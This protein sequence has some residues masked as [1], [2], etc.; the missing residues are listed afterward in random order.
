M[1]LDLKVAASRFTEVGSY[2]LSF[3]SLQSDHKSLLSKVRTELSDVTVAPNFGDGTFS[4][5]LTS[6]V[7]NATVSV[8]AFRI[9][10]EDSH[11]FEMH[12]EE[13]PIFAI[14]KAKNIG[15]AKIV[16][17][18]HAPYLHA[19]KTV[20]VEAPFVKQRRVRFEELAT[21]FETMLKHPRF[22]AAFEDFLLANNTSRYLHFYQDCK[23][24]I[25]A[26][27]A[28]PGHLQSSVYF[29]DVMG[30]YE[31]Y[32]HVTAA[33]HLLTD[34]WVEK[35]IFEQLYTKLE[36]MKAIPNDLK[37]VEILTPCVNEAWKILVEDLH[38]KFLDSRE[39]LT[40]QEK[41]E[42]NTKGLYEINE[43]TGL[44]GIELVQVRTGEKR[45]L[46]IDD[47]M[48]SAETHLSTF[49]VLIRSGK[50]IFKWGLPETQTKPTIVP[51]KVEVRMIDKVMA[52]ALERYR[53]TIL[54]K[55][56]L[57]RKIT[58]L[59]SLR[60]ELDVSI[61][62]CMAKT[63]KS[64]KSDAPVW[65]EELIFQV[66]DL[67]LHGA[68]EFIRFDIVEES[69]ERWPSLGG[70]NIPVEFCRD[71]LQHDLRISFD[72]T[73]RDYGHEIQP[74]TLSFSVEF[75]ASP[76]E[77]ENEM[78]HDVN[79]AVRSQVYLE[80][81]DAPMPMD[82][83]HVL[84]TVQ[85]L[86]VQSFSKYQRFM[87]ATIE[88]RTAKLPTLPFVSVPIKN[89]I[90]PWE[91]PDLHV[92]K[93]EE[94]RNGD[95]KGLEK[96]TLVVSIP[97]INGI[98]KFNAAFKWDTQDLPYGFGINYFARRRNR[99]NF[100]YVGF[101]LLQVPRN[102]EL[103]GTI[104]KFA[105]LESEMKIGFQ[106]GSFPA[107]SGAFR[108][109]S[110]SNFLKEREQDGDPFSPLDAHPMAVLADVPSVNWTA[111][112]EENNLLPTV[113]G[114]DG[115]NEKNVETQAPPIKKPAPPPGKKVRDSPHRSI[116]QI[117]TGVSVKHSNDRPSASQLGAQLMQG[118]PSNL[119]L[120]KNYD[121][122]KSE[123]F[124]E[125]PEHEEPNVLWIK[126]IR[127]PA[128]RDKVEGLHGRLS[129]E[130]D[131]IESMLNTA[132]QHKRVNAEKKSNSEVAMAL[133]KH[134]SMYPDMNKLPT[135]KQEMY[136]QLVEARAE[137]KKT[138]ADNMKLAAL[139]QELQH[140]I[141]VIRHDK[142]HLQK[143]LD[144]TN[145][146]RDSVAVELRLARKRLENHK[147]TV[148]SAAESAIGMR[149]KLKLHVQH[150]TSALRALEHE[151]EKRKRVEQ[152]AR[153]LKSAQDAMEQASARHAAAAAAHMSRASENIKQSNHLE[154][155]RFKI[156]MKAGID[157]AL[158][159][160]KH[161]FVISEH[162]AHAL[163]ELTIHKKEHEHDELAHQLADAKKYIAKLEDELQSMRMKNVTAELAMMEV[164][165]GMPGTLSVND[166]DY[167][168]TMDNAPAYIG[169]DDDDDTVGRGSVFRTKG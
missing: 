143:E 44:L 6:S 99:P 7:P 130:V 12:K 119:P 102:I 70:F 165:L 113:D 42:G 57:S 16:L 141:E 146:K 18:E 135:T 137:T 69:D 123:W 48:G 34:V 36:H 132:L 107:M 88:K 100:L 10:V 58:I 63:S 35:D 14:D 82:C 147:S 47:R 33:Q 13:E 153:E 19:G 53:E 129:E 157:A 89:R 52:G 91:G 151:K 94:E 142:Y 56:I 156:A 24:L 97:T 32:I 85:L 158:A 11:H 38:P 77:E 98:S 83:S 148:A 164:Q 105:G 54:T 116:K 46:N 95:L 59:D 60:R 122:S 68:Y 115:T 49:K 79:R 133:W 103:D 108:I 86:N 31:H 61:S 150:K 160:Q 30:L 144:M 110:A 92:L 28:E 161:A 78:A 17:A 3:S 166:Q 162:K 80:G 106:D 124:E 109:W 114:A 66:D 131:S 64:I 50:N 5:S 29:K 8:T 73:R 136:R 76:S 101:S 81:F 41:L 90:A 67:M 127:D 93:R 154:N 74:V 21:D 155:E 75:R 37:D 145:A 45:Q 43:E 4:L 111:F 128:W 20:E 65:N 118:S 126:R 138:K 25:E 139:M 120:A 112:T 15:T 62:D 125:E 167:A 134:A 104:H 169:V 22:N 23:Q 168:F 72:M 163:Y 87:K 27:K 39:Y 40:L 149:Q 55:D 2:F 1:R 9:G 140:T 96:S 117:H 159:K 51:L 71:G 152:H 121:S 26:K 84:A